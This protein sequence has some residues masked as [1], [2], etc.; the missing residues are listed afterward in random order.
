MA[1]VLGSEAGGVGGGDTIRAAHRANGE[2]RRTG[3]VGR[4]R[5][6]TAGRGGDGAAGRRGE[7]AMGTGDGA[8]A[9][10]WWV[11]ERERERERA[12]VHD[13][14]RLAIQ[15]RARVGPIPSLSSA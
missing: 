3:P 12:G 4:G 15:R 8:A 10:G 6:R 14:R 2:G 5:R 9:V 11:R 13:G 1:E 7:A